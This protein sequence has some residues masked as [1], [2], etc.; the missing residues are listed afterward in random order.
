MGTVSGRGVAR[1][2]AAR[3]QVCRFRVALST[4]ATQLAATYCWITII[5]S[6]SI[7][8]ARS[9]AAKGD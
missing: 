1:G 8:D 2:G 4:R 3:A 5:L 6:F 7:Y 9:A